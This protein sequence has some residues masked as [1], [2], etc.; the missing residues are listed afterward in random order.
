[1]S[2]CGETRSRE[3][4]FDAVVTKVAG[5]S[6][7][8]VLLAIPVIISVITSQLQEVGRNI[9]TFSVPRPLLSRATKS[10]SAINLFCSFFSLFFLKKTADTLFSEADCSKLPPVINKQRDTGRARGK[11]KDRYSVALIGTTSHTMQKCRLVPVSSS[12][13]LF[14][15]VPPSALLFPTSSPPLRSPSISTGQSVAQLSIFVT[16]CLSP[17]KLMNTQTSPN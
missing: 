4:Q 6:E 13:P 16:F 12:S 8:T 11:Q 3:R 17:L 7:N 10:I 5:H 9:C 14:P 15:F 2:F 1:M